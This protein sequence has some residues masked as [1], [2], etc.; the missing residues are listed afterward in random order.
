MDWAACLERYD[1][2]HTLA[3]L[4]PP[5]WGTAG[6]G[7]EFDLDQ[8]TR[9]AELLR[10]MKGKGDRVGERHPRDAPGLRR[11]DDEAASHHLH[12][13]RCRPGEEAGR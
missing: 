5:Y 3:Y 2:P 13:G 8:Y 12:G 7:V 9:V 10:S 11:A 1:R 6:Y 4:D